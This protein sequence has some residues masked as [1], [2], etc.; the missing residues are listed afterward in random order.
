[1]LG[2][3]IEAKPTYQN[4]SQLTYIQQILKEALRL[5]PPAPAF[6]AT[7][8]KD[9]RIG[10]KYDLK[11]GAFV[12]I[13]TLALHRDPK[14]WGPHPDAF[15]PDNFSRE[16]EAKRS[17]NAWKPFGNGQRACIGRGFAMHAI[18]EHVGRASRR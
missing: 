5:W 7:P 18:L 3:D 14:A 12:S 2:A 15:N 11:K 1:M 16:A 6:S 4:V 13:L 8:L 17:P 9:E 10:G